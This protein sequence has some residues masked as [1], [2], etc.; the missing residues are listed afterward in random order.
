MPM[1]VSSGPGAYIA[2]RFVRPTRAADELESINPGCT[3]DVVGRF[4]V[5]P[6]AVDE[7]VAAARAALPAWSAASPR[8]RS[9]VL[10]RFARLVAE[11]GRDLARLITRE[12]GKPLWEAAQEVALVAR[13]VEITLGP[14][15]Q[16]VG[17]FPSP[18]GGVCRFKPKGTL[19]VLGPFNFPVHLPNGH[20]IPALAVGNTVVFKPSETTPAVAV[21]YARLLHRA[22]CPPGVFNMVIGDG[23]VGHRLAVHPEVDGVLFTGSSAVGHRLA[24]ATAGVPGKL[25][26]LEMGGKNAAVVLADADLRLAVRECLFGAFVTSGQRCSAT[27][28]VLVARSIS[29]AFIDA[30]VA[31]ARSLVVGYGLDRGVFMGPLATKA[32]LAKF[33]RAQAAARRE[34]DEALLAAERV[35]TRRPGFYVSPAVHLIRTVRSTSDCQDEEIFGPDVAVYVVD[36]IDDAVALADRTRFGLALSVFSR[37]R[38]NLEPFFRGCRVGVLNWNRAT[39]GA[40]S[41]LPF[42]GQRASGNDRPSALFATDYC[43]YPVAMLPELRGP[44]PPPPPGFPSL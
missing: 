16:R 38:R 43:A 2:G 29:S 28:R 37:R 22:G 44:Q 4:P 35:Q 21:R 36:D 14:G 13:K 33:D 34:G 24:T 1:P 5:W 26:A 7:A 17:P 11:H 27:S 19:A 20:I 3:T 12:M 41:A 18:D 9:A 10:R 23:Q 32:G 25:L 31:G 40:S 15:L 39:V 6:E 8:A 30:F 42:G